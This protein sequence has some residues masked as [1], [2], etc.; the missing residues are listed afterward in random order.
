[1]AWAKMLK[2]ILGPG[3][4][5]VLAGLTLATSVMAQSPQTPRNNLQEPVYRVAKQ[6][7]GQPASEQPTQVQQHPLV[8]AIALAEKSLA[9][10]DNEIKDYTCT[11][12]KRELIDGTL[13][14]HEYIFLK[15]R[16]QPFSVYMYFMAPA[17]IKGRECIYVHGSNQGRLVGHEGGVKGKL[18]GTHDLD[19]TGFIAMRGQR[20]PIT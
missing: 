9:T 8:P 10:I 2:R 19:P 7:D 16:H 3:C 6:P 13:S 14:E 1:M 20:Y 11:L 5:V 17:N 12:V 4:P 15:V 18:L